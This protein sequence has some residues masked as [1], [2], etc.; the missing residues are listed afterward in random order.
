MRSPTGAVAVFFWF[1]VMAPVLVAE[2]FKSPMVDYR[3][4]ALGAAIPLVELFIGH[5]FVLHTLLGS[6]VV[7]TVVMLATVGRRLVRRRL[8]G[9]P[10]GMFFHLALD[11]SWNS[12][13]LFWWPAFGWSLAAEPVPETTGIGWRLLLELA[14]LA[15]AALAVRRYD[16]DQPANRSRLLRTGHLAPNWS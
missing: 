12:A 11:G 5:A 3:L 14:G 15:V 7:L 2:I 9:V 4:V 10:I 8:L 6:V 13:E 16:L 1:V